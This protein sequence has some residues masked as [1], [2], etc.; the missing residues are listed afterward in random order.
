MIEL[1]E[2]YNRYGDRCRYYVN[3]SADLEL[4]ESDSFG[5]VYSRLV[6]QHIEPAYSKTYTRELFRVLASGGLFVFQIPS[7]PNYDALPPAGFKAQ[8]TIQD[9]P[10]SAE[11]GSQLAIQIKVKNISGTTWPALSQIK[12]G[13]HWLDDKE[14]PLVRD[15]GRASLSRDLEPGEESVLQLTVT[16]PAGP[17]D[18]VLELD[19]VQEMIAWFRN[20][21]SRTERFRFQFRETDFKIKRVHFQVIRDAFSK[22]FHKL[23]G[24]LPRVAVEAQGDFPRIEMHSILKSE[25]LDLI[26]TSGGKV[27]DVQDDDAAGPGWLDFCYYV[28]KPRAR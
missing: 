13:N 28:T 18:Y 24:G 25:I 8:I 2:Q 20:L 12:L 10:T 9:P 3:T 5:F 17:D 21:G 16:V 26:E 4:F 6:L 1:A 14:N 11:P 27:L 15:D 7:K 23:G 19:M 22:L